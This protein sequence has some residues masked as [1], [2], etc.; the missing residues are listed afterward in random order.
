MPELDSMAGIEDEVD[1]V[2]VGLANRELVAR[3]L[4]EVTA[5]ERSDE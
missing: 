2:A 3:I 5:E 1:E 4:A